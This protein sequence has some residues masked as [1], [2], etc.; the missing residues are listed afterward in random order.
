MIRGRGATTLAALTGAALLLTGCAND[1]TD[2][3][4]SSAPATTVEASD[5]LGKV[6]E[7][8]KADG[9]Q[10]IGTVR[11]TE[12][13]ELPADCISDSTDLPGSRPLAVRLEIENSEALT[14]SAPDKAIL[15]VNDGQGFTQETENVRVWPQC[16]GTYPKLAEA[17]APGKAAGWVSIESPV[18]DPAAL[19]FTALVWSEDASFDN[20]EVVAVKPAQA[21]IRLPKI[22]PASPAPAPAPAQATSA[23]APVQSVPPVAPPAPTTVAPKPAAPAAGQPC[24]PATQ[25]WATDASGGTLNCG[26][27]GSPTPKWV[28]S[29]P[30]VGVREEGGPCELGAA[31]AESPEGM[32]MVCVGE[33]GSGVWMPGP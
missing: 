14:I 17:P 28:S 1:T 10:K 9:G 32:P 13:A 29:V 5:D 6:Y 23:P 21:V 24:N 16:A 12:V 27:H 22:A 15:K 19:V 31:V 2:T 4:S 18:I 30:Y 3:A 20:W 8:A 26:Y 11:V 33:A 7:F 25:Q